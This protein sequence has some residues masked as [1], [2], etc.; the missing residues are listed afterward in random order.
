MVRP[1]DL[2]RVGVVLTLLGVLLLM[3]AVLLAVV[4]SA[5]GRG[6]WGGVIL[7]GPVPVVVGSSPKMALLA[8]L[9]ALVLMVLALAWW[10]SVRGP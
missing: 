8:A 3:A 4:K 5:S 9:V 10:W 7:I 1:E 6:E 2:V